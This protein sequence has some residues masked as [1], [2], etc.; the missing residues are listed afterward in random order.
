MK[1]YVYICQEAAG[2]VIPGII[3][4]AWKITK[5]FIYLFYD[6]FFQEWMLSKLHKI[7]KI[8]KYF[9]E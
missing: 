2:M 3:I 7:R 1:Q 8:R 5:L 4:A 9:S 6:F